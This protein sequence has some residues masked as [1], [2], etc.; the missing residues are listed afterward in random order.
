MYT[1]CTNE[2]CVVKLHEDSIIL[3]KNFYKDKYNAYRRM[4]STRMKMEITLRTLKQSLGMQYL[5]VCSL[6]VD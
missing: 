5:G 1:L 3:Y 6:N 4:A 2:V